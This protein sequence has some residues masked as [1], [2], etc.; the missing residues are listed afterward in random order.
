MRCTIH[1]KSKAVF[2]KK[3]ATN[4]ESEFFS[5]IELLFVE[6]CGEAV[7]PEASTK[8]L[9][10]AKELETFFNMRCQ[11]RW[12]QIFR[13]CVHTLINNAQ[14]IRR[15]ARPPVGGTLKRLLTIGLC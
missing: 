10:G 9:A 1:P 14:G 3:L 5:T 11:R 13:F 7:S 6:A 2:D 15:E 8:K 4:V 12:R